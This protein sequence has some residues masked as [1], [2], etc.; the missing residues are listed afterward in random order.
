MSALENTAALEVD[1]K[2]KA[3]LEINTKLEAFNQ[4]LPTVVS[5]TFT[6]SINQLVVKLGCI[7]K[8]LLYC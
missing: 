2:A 6:Q 5:S 4:R 8:C 7:E 3:G 1:A